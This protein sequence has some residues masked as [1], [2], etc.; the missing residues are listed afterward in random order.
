MRKLCF[1][2]CLILPALPAF[3]QKITKIDDT[4]YAKTVPVKVEDTT[5]HLGKLKAEIAR[6]QAEYIL[7]A[8]ELSANE[9]AKPGQTVDVDVNADVD[10]DA[11]LNN[12]D[13]PTNP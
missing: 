12:V 1:T 5:D 2:L 4:T 8:A 9:K 6:L 11:E 10:I 13:T 3:A 7:Q